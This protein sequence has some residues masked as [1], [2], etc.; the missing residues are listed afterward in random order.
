MLRPML[1]AALLSAALPLSPVFAHPVA[2]EARTTPA[3][4]TLKWV[5]SHGPAV[6]LIPGMSTP[7]AV[8]DKV[9]P[10]LAADHRVLLVEVKGF[11]TPTAPEGSDK[12]GLI[13]GIVNDIA[14]ELTAAKASKAAIV[15]HS[16][17]GLVGMKL[18]L[19][20]PAVVDRLMVVDALPFFGTV[21]D[22]NA[23]VATIEPRAAT[24]RQ[25][26]VGQAA[27]I[28][29]RAGQPVTG[30]PQNGMSAT[31]EGR[32]QVATWSLNADPLV[33]GEAMYED[34]V[35]DLRKDVARIA[36]PL[37]VVHHS[38]PLGMNDAVYARDYAA[39]PKAKL[40]AVKD[41]AHFVMLDQPERFAAEL[42]AFLKP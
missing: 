29:A 40:V 21:L 30:D 42:A 33:V 16:F 17:G 5:G 6:V 18:A 27:A 37:T 32:R 38:D 1:A 28:R 4:T 20:K 36:V 10:T 14:A 35:T 2:S 23:T 11:A 19:D 25:M 8:W 3:R 31:P 26:M 7:A 9:V 13:D 24:M 39:R 22:P 15:G 12:P 34:M 41:S